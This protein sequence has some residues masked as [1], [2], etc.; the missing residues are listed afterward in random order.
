MTLLLLILD[1]KVGEPEPPGQLADIIEHFHTYQN[2]VSIPGPIITP[3]YCACPEILPGDLLLHFAT[4]ALGN[5]SVFLRNGLE[6]NGIKVFESVG[7]SL[8]V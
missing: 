5:Q 6:I 4:L 2:G 7:E 3:A 8:P 1:K